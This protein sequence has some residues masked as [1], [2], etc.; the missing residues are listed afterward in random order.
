MWQT[1]V[2]APMYN[3]LVALASL[4]GGSLGWAVIG[5]TLA[6]KLILLPFSWKTHL[7]QILQKKLQP[8]IAKIKKD[9]PDQAEQSMKIMAL[10]KESGSNP[11]AGC[12]PM[13]IQLPIL[14]GMYQ[15]FFRGI[16]GGV[17]LLYSSVT[18]PSSISTQ[19]LG[20]DL[21]VTSL[22]FA[23]AAGIFQ[24]AQLLLSPTMKHADPNDPQAKM[25]KMMVYIIPVMITI[26][27]AT[28][29]ASLSL[30]FIIN[31]LASILQDAVFTKITPR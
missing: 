1:L 29:P 20:T 17:G 28:L 10:Y 26:A 25:S 22:V 9:F 3:I 27:G 4:F 13:L 5:L 18:L 16:E 23:V 24:A 12:L 6:V 21:A 11:F 31:A 15:V 8:Q 2:I 30:Y 7:T 14:L 19:F